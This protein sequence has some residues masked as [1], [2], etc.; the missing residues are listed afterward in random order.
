M[1]RMHRGSH[2]RMSSFSR[3]ILYR[4]VFW[5]H[6]KNAKELEINKDKYIPG[7]YLI[8]VLEPHFAFGRMNVFT[9]DIRIYVCIYYIPGILV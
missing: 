7:M 1:I 3:N 9:Y 5:W 2:L 4:S 8:H 6:H